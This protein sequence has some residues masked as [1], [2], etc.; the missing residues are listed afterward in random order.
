MA[1]MMAAI[2]QAVAIHRPPIRIQRTFSN[3]ETGG[4]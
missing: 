3:I 4:M 2:T 1:M